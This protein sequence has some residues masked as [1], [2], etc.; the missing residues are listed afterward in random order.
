MLP[1][2]K[3]VKGPLWFALFKFMD[4]D[5][6][7]RISFSELSRG[8]REL[9]RMKEGE[10]PVARL[11]ALWRALDEDCSGYVSCGEFGKFMRKGEGEGQQQRVRNAKAQLKKSR[12]DKS[13][14]A[15]AEHE[16]RVGRDLAA[17]WKDVPKASKKEAEEL[18]RVVNVRFASKLALHR[19]GWMKFF[20][21]MDDD[22][23]GRIAYAELAW[24]L[25]TQLG[26]SKKEL[27]ELQLQ[28]L[29][30]HL[31][32][33]ASG[34]ICAGEFLRFVKRGASALP[35]QQ[36]SDWIKNQQ[37]S[38]VPSTLAAISPPSPAY[39][40]LPTTCMTTTVTLLQATRQR[41]TA[42][43]EEWEGNALA[44]AKASCLSPPS[45]TATATTLHKTSCTIC[46]VH[47]TLGQC[48]G[49]TPTRSR[50]Q[51]Q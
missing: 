34:F 16:A 6:S 29:W 27:P 7:G 33:D 11:Q 5:R 12:L 46:S 19:D 2:A 48:Q 17:R 13:A 49:E 38:G 31:D 47:F 25:R 28:A 51:H 4:D 44:R 8:V 45:P 50:P 18:S 36:D 24:G 3:M 1:D 40:G 41:V 10:M 20:R 32:A 43:E 22:N 21:L 15:S 26:F 9:L 23:S 35:E 30:K 37:A 39:S 42:E 14:A